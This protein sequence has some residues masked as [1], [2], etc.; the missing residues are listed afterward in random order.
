M[1]NNQHTP[2]PKGNPIWFANVHLG[3]FQKSELKAREFMFCTVAVQFQKKTGWVQPGVNNGFR[4]KYPLKREIGVSV[5]IHERQ[6][7][8]T[9]ADLKQNGY[10]EESE[11]RQ[12]WRVT[13]KFWVLKEE[14]EKAGYDHDMTYTPPSVMEDSVSIHENLPTKLSFKNSKYYNNPTLFAQEVGQSKWMDGQNVDFEFYHTQIQQFYTEENPNSAYVNWTRRC[15]DWIIEKIQ[16]RSIVRKKEAPQRKGTIAQLSDAE[17]T[18]ELDMW[19]EKMLHPETESFEEY[20]E[21]AQVYKAYAKEALN[22]GDKVLNANGQKLAKILIS[23]INDDTKLRETFEKRL[24]ERDT[25][26]DPPP[27]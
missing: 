21:T 27:S 22:R 17:L 9:Y 3:A 5:K 12:M 8:Y 26:P 2:A 18:K 24:R 13:S 6:M 25:N 10:I 15:Q 20:K 11:C 1:I 16:N 4:F 23:I 19:Y 7:N 14:M